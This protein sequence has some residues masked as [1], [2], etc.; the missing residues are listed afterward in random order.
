MLIVTIFVTVIRP[1]GMCQHGPAA[2]CRE[3]D[4]L[5][6]QSHRG[7]AGP[8]T[9]D[10]MIGKQKA[11][12]A[13]ARLAVGGILVSAALA[14]TAGIASAAPGHPL[15]ATVSASGTGAHASWNGNDSVKLTVGSS[16]GTYAQVALDN[17]PATAPLTAPSFSTNNYAQ[18]SPRWVIE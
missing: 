6:A 10:N 18:G 17:P 11:A 15:P 5:T 1:P 12:G 9:R 16:S 3:A 14:G 2:M 4:L 7:R 8:R 13:G